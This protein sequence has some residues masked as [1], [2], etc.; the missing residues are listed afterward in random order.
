MKAIE[1]IASYHKLNFGTALDVGANIGNHSLYFSGLFRKVLSFEPSPVLNLVLQANILRNEI[2]NVQV[3]GCGLGN[4]S[5]LAVVQELS[6]NH[7]GMVQLNTGPDVSL[8]DQSDGVEIFRGDDVLKRDANGKGIISFIKI[9]VE[10]MELQVLEGL[11]DTISRDQPL[12]AFES[13]SYQEGIQVM[14]YLRGLGYQYF[15][16]LQSSRLP[17]RAFL[18][19]AMRFW[20]ESAT[21]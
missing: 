6:E 20:G 9:D 10:G 19:L 8:T 14:S 17:P 16:E 12:I 2:D 5:G 11:S 7:T 21:V 1:E 4:K 15:Y 13:R 18:R 3:F